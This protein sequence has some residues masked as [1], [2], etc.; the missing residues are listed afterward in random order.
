MPP[1][2]DLQLIPTPE[3]VEELG[4]RFSAMTFTGVNFDEE[5]CVFL[6]GSALVC[7]GLL[8]NAQNEILWQSFQGHSFE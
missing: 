7:S 4:K 2:L 3:L 6:H 5:V 1:S 8:T